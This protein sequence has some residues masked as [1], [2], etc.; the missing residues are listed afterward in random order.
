MKKQILTFIIGVLVGAA[1]TAA[2][3]LIFKPKN[4]RQIPDFKNFNKDGEKFNP[5]DGDFDPSKFKSG[6]GRSRRNKDS[7]ETTDD[8]KVE[9]KKTEDSTNEKQG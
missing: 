5:E 8:N 6:E 4:S 1:I 9:E 2:I 3:F 7:S